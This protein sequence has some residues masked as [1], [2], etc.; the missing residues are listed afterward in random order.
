MQTL[1]IVIAVVLTAVALIPVVASGQGQADLV[2]VHGKIW[3]ENPRQPEVEAVAVQGNR[4]VEVGDSESVLKLTGPKTRIVDLQG[5][6]VVPGHDPRRGD[7][8]DCALGTA[9]L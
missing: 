2:L 4:I 9:Q 5:R 1:S 3:T 8:D 6:R 7:D